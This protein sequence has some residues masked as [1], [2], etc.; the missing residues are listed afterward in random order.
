MMRD[1][2]GVHHKPLMRGPSLAGLAHWQPALVAL[3]LEP[4]AWPGLAAAV[5]A[6]AVWLSAD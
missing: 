4:E 6:T 2:A 1:L 5:A 3:W